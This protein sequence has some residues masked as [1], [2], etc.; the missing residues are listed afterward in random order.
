MISSTAVYAIPGLGMSP[1]IFERL[2][3]TCGPLRPVH[4]IEPHDE[5]ESLAHYGLRLSE[6][7]A[8]GEGPITL[9]GMSFGGM[10]A[11]QLAR[12]LPVE[13]VIL[14]STLKTHHEKPAWLRLMQQVPLYQ[15]NRRWGRQRTLRYWAPLFG[16]DS[17]EHQA[18]CTPMFAQYSDTYWRWA[19]RQIVEWEST[20]PTVD[21]LHLHGDEDR[22]FPA[23]DIFDY[24][25]IEQGDHFMV[26]KQPGLLSVRIDEWLAAPAVLSAKKAL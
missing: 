19:V 21:Y 26:Y 15:L 14:I 5:A 25:R 8:A 22:I 13:R 7:I 9:I 18:F 10:M 23:T 2:A 17:P 3:L 12:M 1:R 4:W 6:Q 24:Q 16:I 20:G 11:V